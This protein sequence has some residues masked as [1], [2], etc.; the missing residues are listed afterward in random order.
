[1]SYRTD[2][3]TD[4]AVQRCI[5]RLRQHF[6]DKSGKPIRTPFYITQL[7]VLYQKDFFAWIISD[8]I[9]ILTQ[10]AFLASF[11]LT[12]IPQATSKLPNLRNLIFVIRKETYIKN[13]ALAKT[14]ALN[15]ARYVNSYSHPQVTKALGDHLEGLVTYEIKAHQFSIAARHTNEYKGRKWTA[16]VHDL[17]LIAE[18]ASGSLNIGVEVKNRLEL[19]DP[20]LIDTKIDMCH[21]LGFVPVFAVRW[22]KPY[23]DCIRNQ[24]GFSWMFKTQIYSP[25]FEQFTRELYTRLST[26]TRQDSGGH[27]LE[28]PVAVRTSIPE[29]SAKRF[30]DWVQRAIENPPQANPMARCGSRPR[31]TENKENQ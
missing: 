5:L 22:I 23:A 2:P 16:T 27:P 20:S 3:R 12:D 29:G 25:G 28:F 30:N 18:H 4:P 15:I 1:M 6:T 7:Q 11:P 19:M 31:E 17:D 26:P 8:A 21:S 10:D 13:P 9:R 14:H 24:G